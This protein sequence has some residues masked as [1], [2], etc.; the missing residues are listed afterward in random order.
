M[1]W[2]LY[3]VEYTQPPAQVTVTLE[4]READALVT[5][6]SA[7]KRNPAAAEMLLTMSAYIAQSILRL[8]NGQVLLAEGDDEGAVIAISLPKA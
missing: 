1:N 8:H 3:L 6:H 5:F 7:G 4:A 2:I